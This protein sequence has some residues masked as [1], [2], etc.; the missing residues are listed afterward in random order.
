MK[1]ILAQTLALAAALT[2]IGALAIPA[3]A[4]EKEKKKGGLPFNGKITAVD[5]TAKTI[6]LSG[7]QARVL[8]VSAKTKIMKGDQAGTFEDLKVGEQV[9]GS[10]R[11]AEGKLVAASIRIGGAPA[12]E[13]KK[14]T[15]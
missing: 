2:V 10:Y 12:G 11:E 8:E 9:S 7:K 1:R 14:K 3:A 4:Q 13:K 15:E 5:S 6:T